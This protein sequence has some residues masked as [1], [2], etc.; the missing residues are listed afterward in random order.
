MAEPEG[1]SKV[2]SMASGWKQ[3][4]DAADR[5]FKLAEE[6]FLQCL[7]SVEC[8]NQTPVTVTLLNPDVHLVQACWLKFRK[9]VLGWGCTA[10][11]RKASEEERNTYRAARAGPVYFIQVTIP[12]SAHQSY[13]TDKRD[14]NQLQH[15]DN[16]P[17]LLAPSQQQ[18][19][20]QQQQQQ[21]VDVAQAALPPLPMAESH[22]RPGES[23][24][25][26]AAKP[27]TPKKKSKKAKNAYATTAEDSETDYEED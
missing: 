22:K 20:Q 4:S 27:A 3:I 25:V 10:K 19:Q 15:F 6:K 16:G 2:R 11:R 24:D 23:D 8:N 12:L 21:P 14:H 26:L 13:V 18:H 9:M 1:T 7:A 17:T 5:R